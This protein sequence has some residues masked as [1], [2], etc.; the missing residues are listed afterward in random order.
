MK[1]IVWG[2]GNIAKNFVLERVMYREFDI[3]SFTDN[4]PNL[5]NTEF[6][7]IRILSP[8][9]ALQQE[10]DAVFIWNSFA[11]EITRQ[12]VA[13]FQVKENIIFSYQDLE[14]KLCQ[15]LCEKYKNSTD[16][17]IKKV[18]DYYRHKGFNIYGYYE[19]RIEP[20]CFVKREDDG[21][22]FIMYEN[23]KMYYPYHYK[24][25]RY[26]GKECVFDV[27]Y[28]Q[29]A[30][31]PHRYVTENNQ[32]EDGSIIVDAGVRE[33]NFSLKYVEMAKKIYLIESDLEWM[34][35]LKKTFE[36]YK[37]KIVFC[38]KFLTDYDS[39][40]TITLDSLVK[41]KIDFLKM[42][43]EGAEVDALLGGKRVLQESNA[44]CAICSY[45]KMNDAE[46]ISWIMNHLGYHISESEG[47]MFFV[48]DRAIADTMDFRKG[49]VYA[50]KG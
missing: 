40:T 4:N 24:F 2:T 14:K 43:I 36:K 21:W 46:N 22:P 11:D 27:S 31:S 7:G 20:P 32:M 42:D 47:Y 1:A 8:Q 26:D 45:H 35:A 48:F 49:I 29:G 30:H 16:L 39:R 17:Q 34:E 18:L 28:E 37:D 15:D 13:E 6:N 38:S 50:D 23:K 9:E 5:W 25:S 10:Y 19:G 12:L 3:V 33:G 41:E 44:H